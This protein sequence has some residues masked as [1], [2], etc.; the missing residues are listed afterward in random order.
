M[1]DKRFN[2]RFG[3]APEGMVTVVPRNDDELLR[4]AMNLLEELDAADFLA[5]EHKE[6]FRALRRAWK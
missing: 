2:V 6:E 4:R 3:E 5:D 1:A